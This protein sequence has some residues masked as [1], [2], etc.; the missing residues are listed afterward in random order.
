MAPGGYC[1]LD[2]VLWPVGS[3]APSGTGPVGDISGRHV[4]TR[5]LSSASIRPGEHAART[6]LLEALTHPCSGRDDGP[7]KARVDGDEPRAV[8]AHHAG[9]ALCIRPEMGVAHPRAGFSVGR[10]ICPGCRGSP[11]W[12]PAQP[13][14]QRAPTTLTVHLQ[15]VTTSTWNGPVAPFSCSVVVS[16]RSVPNSSVMTSGNAGLTLV[17]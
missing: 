14:G 9:H 17:P 11:G 7:W 2:A 1:D 3:D 8:P 5:G 6:P 15:V 12:Y 13:A 10:R 4:S 16:E